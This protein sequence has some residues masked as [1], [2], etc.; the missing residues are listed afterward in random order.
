MGALVLR[1]VTSTN[2]DAAIRAALMK[3]GREAPRRSFRRPPRCGTQSRHTPNSKEY[4]RRWHQP[5]LH[6]SPGDPDGVRFGRVCLERRLIDHPVPPRIRTPPHAKL[7]SSQVA[8]GDVIALRAELPLASASRTE[9]PSVPVAIRRGRRE[10][11]LIGF[12][13]TTFCMAAVPRVTTDDRR[14]PLADTGFDPPH[15][16]N[17]LPLRSSYPP[18]NGRQTPSSSRCWACWCYRPTTPAARAGRSVGGILPP[19]DEP[20]SRL[21]PARPAEPRLAPPGA[22]LAQETTDEDDPIVVISGD[23]QSPRARPSTTGSSSS[24]A[25]S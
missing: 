4:F 13:P 6:G 23:G 8:A 5:F 24:T 9:R 11:R 18:R 19:S 16:P 14:N 17:G 20:A 10:E 1:S 2:V 21:S 25:T 12:E 15:R 7:I 22:A 3:R